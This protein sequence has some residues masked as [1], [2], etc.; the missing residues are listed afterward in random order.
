MVIEGKLF[1]KLDVVQVSETFTKRDFVV[2][3]IDGSPLHP[4]YISFQCVRERCALI[5]TFAVGDQIEVTF[6]LRGREWTSPQGEK[7]YFN[8]LE[9]WRISKVEASASSPAANGSEPAYGGE[10]MAGDTSD[11]LPF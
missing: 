11:D 7:K 1:A 5:D 10:D 8:T 4:Q 3:F 9:A 6:N 2:E